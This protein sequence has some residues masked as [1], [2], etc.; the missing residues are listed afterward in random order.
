M[1]RSSAP[2]PKVRTVRT[3]PRVRTVL[4]CHGAR[5]LVVGLVL[6]WPLS[7]SAQ[8]TTESDRVMAAVRAAMAPALAF[9][10]TDETG[11]VPANGS[12]VPSWMVR[13]L[14]P[15]EQSIEVMANPLNEINQ[16]RAMRAM[17]QIGAAVDAAQRRAE[18]QYERALS[19]AKRTGRSQDVDGVG[20]SD[21]G[22]AGARID[23][24]AHV[25]IDVDFNQPSYT[26]GIESSVAP[27]PS[28]QVVIAGAAAVITVPSNVFRNA[29]APRPEDRFCPAEAVVFFG[30]LA[31]PDIRERSEHVFD[32]TTSALATDR[33][34]AVRTMTLRLRGNETLIAEILSKT[35]WTQV[36]ELLK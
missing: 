12:P 24:E 32:V 8:G 28:R 6:A 10:D 13:P 29:K 23:A 25:T 19:E 20:L 18:L 27:A 30:S 21:E 4:G 17:A 36:Q 26:F 34:P 2:S 33:S 1:G 16:A 15:G 31:V 35:D 3:V 14:Q 9:P 11:S 7:A 22:I 5:V